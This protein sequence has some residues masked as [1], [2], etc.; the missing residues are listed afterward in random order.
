MHIIPK[1]ELFEENNN[2]II[3]K[4]SGKLP[5]V[6]NIN[7]NALNNTFFRKTIWTGSNLQMTLMTVEDSIGLEVHDVDQFIRIESGECLIE[8]GKSKD[9]LDFKTNANQNYGIFIPAG[10]YHNI[11]KIGIIELKLSAI[12]A[13]VEHEKGTINIKK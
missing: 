8:M 9:S 5:T 12:Y 13:P 11:T 1:F 2:I 4:D 3:E 10:Y 7:K 6:I